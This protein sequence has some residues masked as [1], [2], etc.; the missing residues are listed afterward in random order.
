LIICFET[1]TVFVTNKKQ[2]RFTRCAALFFPDMNYNFYV[3]EKT[4][5]YSLDKYHY[6]INDAFAN[7]GKI[8]VHKL[9]SLS[10]R[11]EYYSNFGNNDHPI[12][13]DTTIE[14]LL[15]AFLNNADNI[16]LIINVCEVTSLMF[17]RN[18]IPNYEDTKLDY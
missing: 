18:R 2:R 13:V 4:F 17:K 11:V 7:S 15:T 12:T 6:Y 16:L 9:L 14:S 8:N 10:T 3:I 1:G 5:K